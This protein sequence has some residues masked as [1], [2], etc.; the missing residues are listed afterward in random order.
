M[1]S[2]FN[3]K[4]MYALTYQLKEVQCSRSAHNLS[5]SG[6]DNGLHDV[7]WITLQRDRRTT[8][9]TQLLARIRCQSSD[10]AP[11]DHHGSTPYADTFYI[12]ELIVGTSAETLDILKLFVI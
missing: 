2:V 12:V 11:P 5:K 6:C 8:E 7:E 4:Y 9:H 10:S 1:H 3:H